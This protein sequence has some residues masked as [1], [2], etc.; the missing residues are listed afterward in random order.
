MALLIDVSP[1]CE[2][3]TDAAL[4][5][6]YK[7]AASEPPD[8]A[9]LWALHPSPLVRRI[10]ELFTQRGL[11][12]IAGL[13][14]ELRKWLAGDMAVASHE[15]RGRPPGQMERWTRQELGIVKLYL[16]TLPP[17]E[18]TL[19]DWMLLADYLAQRY[20]PPD[21]LR[22]EAEWL[23]TRSAIMGRV[24]ASLGEVTEE[25]AD[26]LLQAM[27][28]DLAGA[29]ASVGLTLAQHAALQY[30]NARCAENVVALSDATRH[31]LRRLIMDYA[32]AQFLGDR[33]VM[34]SSLQTKLLD[35]FGTLNRDWRRIAVT[36]ATENLNQGMVAAQQPGTR[37]KRIEQY[38]GACTF[39]RAID[40][41]VMEVIPASEPEK[42]GTTQIW[43][44][45]NN[46]GRS[47]APRRRVGNSLIDR[48]PH[49]MWWVASG[50][51]HPNCRGRWV[52]VTEP[53]RKAD[54]KFSAWMD[55]A[56]G[57]N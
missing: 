24:Q 46:I 21:D 42:D 49:E 16:E 15:R 13:Q 22:T 53:S 25:Q 45:K 44:G 33:A 30:G 3:H 9:D 14:N 31:R 38:R 41:R 51:Q 7:A 56:L 40:G 54:P 17:A 36:E 48:E 6:I 55:E 23:A 57:R 50:A 37:L 20:L 19:D 32:E 5:L 28:R 26:R 47:A 12:R 11:R 34:A 35:T 8:D 39:C 10:V 2:H 27:P 29:K 43:T 52:P 4:E 18:F 1:L